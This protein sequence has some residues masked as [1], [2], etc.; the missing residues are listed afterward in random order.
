MQ[1][2]LGFTLAI[3]GLALVLLAVLV[4]LGIVTPRGKMGIASDVS[5]AD[6][7]KSLLDKVPWLCLVGL[8]LIYMGLRT[9]GVDLSF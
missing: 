1:S 3:L 7:V 9:L 2:A 5:W 6:V 8:A 4:W